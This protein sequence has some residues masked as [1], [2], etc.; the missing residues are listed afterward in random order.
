MRAKWI[1]FSGVL[2][3]YA[4]RSADPAR[5]F[6]ASGVVDGS[7]ESGTDN[8][9]FVY[10]LDVGTRLAQADG[11]TEARQIW[12]LVNLTACKSMLS[13]SETLLSC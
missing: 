5:S 6:P 3:N 10:R 12:K 4:K 7:K 8:R 1:R 13:G 2:S 11:M 9:Y